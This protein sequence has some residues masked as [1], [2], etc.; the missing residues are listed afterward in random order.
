MDSNPLNNSS[1]ASI[2]KTMINQLPSLG[3]EFTLT[4]GYISLKNMIF[5]QTNGAAMGSP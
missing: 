3:M 2:G 5:Q 4:K 1:P